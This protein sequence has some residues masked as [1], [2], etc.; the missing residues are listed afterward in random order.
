M[1]FDLI[2]KFF[3]ENWLH[4]HH[5]ESYNDLIA[6]RIPKIVNENSDV[7]VDQYRVSFGELYFSRPS[8]VETNGM[9][10]FISPYEASSCRNISYASDIYCDITLIEPVKTHVHTKVHIGSIPVMVGSDLCNGARGDDGGYFIV[11]GME[12]VIIPQD[13]TRFNNPYVYRNRKTPPKFEY[14]CEIRSSATAITRTTTTQIGIKDERIYAIVPYIPDANAIP[15]CILF[16]ALGVLDEVDIIK[17]IVNIDG[18][19]AQEV[20]EFMRHSLEHA[21]ECRTQEDALCYIGYK[22]KKFVKGGDKTEDDTKNDAISYATYLVTSELFPHLGTDLLKKR[23]YVGY[24]ITKLLNS[25]KGRTHAVD[26]DH[27]ANK[28][29]DADGVLMSNLFYIAFRKL[30]G[31]IAKMITQRVIE[32]GQQPSIPSYVNPDHITRIFRHAIATGNWGGHKGVGSKAGVTQNYERFNRITTISHQRRIKT[33]LGTKGKL[34][35]PRRLH[36]SHL[37]HICVSETPEGGEIG[38]TK[39]LALLEYITIGCDIEPLVKLMSSMPEFVEFTENTTRVMSSTKIVVNG[40]LLGNTTDAKS[41]YGRLVSF[42]RT[43]GISPETSISHDTEQNELRLNTDAGRY[44]RPLI[45]VNNGV[46]ATD[47]TDTSCM[48]WTELITSGIVE[49]LDADELDC[50]DVLIAME[51]G[52]ITP[53][54][55]HCELHPAMMYGVNAGL[56]PYANHNPAPRLTY[57]ASMGKQGIGSPSIDHNS[58]MK[59]FYHLLH[60]PQ[61]PLVK[62]QIGDL[63]DYDSEPTGANVVTA[64]MPFEGFGQEDSIILNQASVDRGLFN[65]SK[66]KSFSAVIKR[67]KHVALAIPSREICDRFRGNDVSALSTTDDTAVLGTLRM[68]TDNTKWAYSPNHQVPFGVAKIGSVIRKGNVI[69]GIVQEKDSAKIVPTIADTKLKKYL[70]ASVIY[71]ED[72]PCRVTRV[73]YGYNGDGYFF[74][75]VKVC[76]LRIPEIGDKFASRIAQKG[77]CGRIVR[78]EDMPFSGDPRSAPCPDMIINPLAFPSRMTIGQIVE[79]VVGMAA[80]IEG[81]PSTDATVFEEFSVDRL[82]SKLEELKIPN[83]GKCVMYNGMTGERMDAFIFMGVTYYQRL[84]HMVK[85]KVHA[86]ARGPNHAFTRQ[87][88]E[89]RANDGGLRM[90]EMER[91]CLLGHG[92]SNVLLDRL[93]RNSD[94][95]QCNVCK[96]CGLIV[97]DKCTTCDVSD[98]STINIPYGTKLVFQ[99]LMGCGIYPRIL[100]D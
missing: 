99:E 89:G 4:G 33:S 51:R 22:G 98:V 11:D 66:F 100:T 90:G 6:N 45:I 12:K 78:Q 31:E 61:K 80:S 79:S 38:L 27:L 59:G 26:R 91:D 97:T 56:I 84:K 77:T 28:R 70:D 63:I 47:N 13:R 73:H 49:Y 34:T 92:A 54:H 64:I 75:A 35:A 17:H 46:L 53:E 42:R 71:D 88:R 82:M 52:D 36:G 44:S 43:G 9:K 68:H 10:R 30:R 40:D 58:I 96:V 39:Q 95:Y 5:I 23:Y 2:T 15:I 16:R 87:P 72:E 21:Y 83:A 65:S 1:S 81:V 7:V 32:K 93:F 67:T 29:V 55:T 19:E 14:F 50:S 48:T 24:L 60:T 69:I 74:V 57:Q 94:R 3:E 86:R 41:M 85:D 37:G 25:I 20:I 8:H 62:T 18:I 76:I